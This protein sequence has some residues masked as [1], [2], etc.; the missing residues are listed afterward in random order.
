M[1]PFHPSLIVIAGDYT[2]ILSTSYLYQYRNPKR[3]P[4][5]SRFSGPP[6]VHS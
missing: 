4:V 2:T 5:H 6:V 3:N 1:S